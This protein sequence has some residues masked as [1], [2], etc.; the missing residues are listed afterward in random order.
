MLALSLRIVVPGQNLSKRLRDA[1][2]FHK[3]AG[4]G[5]GELRVSTKTERRREAERLEAMMEAEEQ[6]THNYQPEG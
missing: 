3:I 6:Q 5:T 4:P 2:N 1:E